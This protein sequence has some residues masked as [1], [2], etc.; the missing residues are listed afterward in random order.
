MADP[1]LFTI[2]CV[3]T[4]NKKEEKKFSV[5][6][7]PDQKL[8]KLR[9][10]LEAQ[11]DL[12]ERW[13]FV[14][15]EKGDAKAEKADAK[16]EKADAKPEKADAKPEKA[17]AKAEKADAQLTPSAEAKM[18]VATL[19]GGENTLEL[20][21]T[22]DLAKG[23]A[24]AA[25]EIQE[26]LKD[27]NTSLAAVKQALAR[28]K[29]ALLSEA[30]RAA[31][32]MP[33]HLK[34]D[35]G[36]WG[37]DTGTSYRA[38]PDG[39][40]VKIVRSLGLPRTARREPDESFVMTEFVARLTAPE[41]SDDPVETVAKEYTVAANEVETR[42]EKFAEAWQKRSFESGFMNISAALQLSFPI[43]SGR[44]GISGSYQRSEQTEKT[45]DSGGSTLYIV[46]SQEVRKARV[47]VPV[48]MIA[49]ADHVQKRFVNAVKADSLSDEKILEN[50]ELLLNEYGYFVITEY[51]LGA[52][53]TTFDELKGIDSASA[54]AKA[55]EWQ[56]AAAL[57]FKHVA[58]SGEASGGVGKGT[59]EKSSDKSTSERLSFRIQAK[60]GNVTE[61]HD[62]HAWIQSIRP[63]NWE[64]I[65]YG[66]LM[67]IYEFIN[68][69]DVRRHCE[70]ALKR[71]TN[72]HLDDAVA[73]WATNS[74]RFSGVAGAREALPA[75][76][77][78][79][80]RTLQEHEL[81]AHTGWVKVPEKQFF[82]GARLQVRGTR[83]TLA[84]N[85]VDEK[86]A[87]QPDVSPSDNEV[88]NGQ[89][90]IGTKLI[91]GSNLFFDTTPVDIPAGH[92]IIA[93]RLRRLDNPPNR[94]G[95]EVQTAKGV[96]DASVTTL[97]KH[98][99]DNRTFID[100]DMDKLFLSCERAVAPEGTCIVGI[101]LAK[102]GQNFTL[103][104][105]LLVRPVEQ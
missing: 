23:E 35:P 79:H 25:K 4:G 48:D 50:L 44:F 5:Y 82:R 90:Y 34:R 89:D 47:F 1:E 67:P 12:P 63:D 42:V 26:Q 14:K 58:G 6:L 54:E 69:I 66:R 95:L 59:S 36:R 74:S 15:G 19:A 83:L 65:A 9:T 46:G 61:R 24:E 84:L 64:V 33:E 32:A 88:N 56:V 60:G 13:V 21:V 8:D 96:R 75:H 43:F 81:Y 93:L 68:D 73:L 3:T 76:E 57:S 52:K 98:H 87:P 17:D 70:S 102:H 7:D 45:R 10:D 38:L 100:A 78:S 18:S 71:M 11:F 31:L 16:P 105:R 29:D 39:E 92:R 30:E 41:D 62:P 85:V 86:M 104:V 77:G 20:R 53:L 99:G 80:N 37:G 97:I 72:R 40:L 22:K 27:L 103:G 2:R 101:H 91:K 28:P 49:L 94:I 51:V 55:V